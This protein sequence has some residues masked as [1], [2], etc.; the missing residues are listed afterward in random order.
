MKGCN[1]LAALVA[2]LLLLAAP[3]LAAAAE[4]GTRTKTHHRHFAH[5]QHFVD[6]PPQPYFR[7]SIDGH[8]IDSQG[9]RFWNGQWDNTCFRTLDYLPSASACSG[10]GFRR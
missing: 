4:A 9:W 7:R 2:A 5:Y 1:K 10:G 6:G 3:L 8:P